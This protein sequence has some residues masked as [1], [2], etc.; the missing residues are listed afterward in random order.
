MRESVGFINKENCPSILELVPREVPFTPMDA[1]GIG[2]L[3]SASTTVPSSRCWP[4]AAKA[5]AHRKAI[6]Q[7]NFLTVR[8]VLGSSSQRYKSANKCSAVQP[9]RETPRT[10]TK[11]PEAVW[12]VPSIYA[13]QRDTVF[14]H[15]NGAL[16]IFFR[17]EFTFCS[18]VRI[19]VWTFS[20]FQVNETRQETSFLERLC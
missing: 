7:I 18:P 3:L 13:R 14:L 16:T 1:K 2:F 4:M 6:N 5:A 20:T 19:L 12:L 9:S 17:Q 11:A 8:S 15:K 10:C